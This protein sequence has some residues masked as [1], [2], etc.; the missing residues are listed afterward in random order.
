[1]RVKSQLEFWKIDELLL[2][3]LIEIRLL[4]ED[5]PI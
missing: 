2:G 3:K 1:M 4:V 5:G